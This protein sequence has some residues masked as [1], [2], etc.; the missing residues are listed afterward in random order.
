MSD[1]REHDVDRFVSIQHYWRSREMKNK[2][3]PG[4]FGSFFSSLLGE[5]CCGSGLFFGYTI[6]CAR[7]ISIIIRII[8]GS[9]Y[10]LVCLAQLTKCSIEVSRWSTNC[11]S[12]SF[13][14]QSFELCDIA[15]S[16]NLRTPDRRNH[17]RM[18]KR[19]I[20]NSKCRW[21][22]NWIWFWHKQE[23]RNL[24]RWLFSSE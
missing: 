3:H 2:W 20:I 1:P 15:A 22:A 18:A 7:L 4:Y 16:A 8:H 19:K 10:C 11:R 17:R 5:Y 14:I 13:V 23:R 9:I 24:A 12:N 21:L 6:A